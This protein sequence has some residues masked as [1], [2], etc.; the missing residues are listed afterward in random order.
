MVMVALH[1]PE[2]FEAHAF[3]VPE[4]STVAYLQN[5]FAGITQTLGDYGNAFIS[6]VK[7]FFEQRN[8]SEALRKARAALSMA[9]GM[10]RN[11]VYY[12]DNLPGLQQA[13]LEMQRW[14]MAN[15]VIRERYNKQL[16]DGYSDSYIDMEPGTVGESQYDYRRVMHGV[17]QDL[18]ADETGETGW[19]VT[20]YLDEERDGDRE[21]TM[22]ERD[23]ILKTWNVAAALMIDGEEDP[24]SPY[25][26]SL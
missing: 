5:Q 26:S 16:C 20:F 9:D 12:I 22:D 6:R 2:F 18:P 14:I 15:P 11:D 10:H 8:S 19:K 25:G 7:G 24:T 21:L 4:Q 23:D 17:L 3:G 1:A 13:P